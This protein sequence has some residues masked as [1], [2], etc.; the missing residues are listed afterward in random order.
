MTSIESRVMNR[1]KKCSIIELGRVGRA[2][3]GERR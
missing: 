3:N 1:V 2:R